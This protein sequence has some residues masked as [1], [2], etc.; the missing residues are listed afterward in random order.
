MFK[1]NI[2]I[3]YRY[4]IRYLIKLNYLIGIILLNSLLE[5]KLF[6]SLLVDNKK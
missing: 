2:F 5:I 3:I 1:L 4:I 6:I